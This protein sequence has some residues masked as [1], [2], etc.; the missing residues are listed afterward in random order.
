MAYLGKQLKRYQ[1]IPTKHSLELEAAVAAQ[2]P[3]AIT[4]A[5]KMP[6]ISPS[7]P[8]IP[9]TAAATGK[10]RLGWLNL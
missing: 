5:S 4:P 10:S 9:A 1:V 2:A 7:K 3:S 6:S 8:S